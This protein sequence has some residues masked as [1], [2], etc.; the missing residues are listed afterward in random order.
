LIAR[1]RWSERD[2][3][4]TLAVRIAGTLKRAAEVELRL[5]GIANRPAALIA[6]KLDECFRLIAS[7]LIGHLART[8]GSTAASWCDSRIDDIP[9]EGGNR[10]GRRKAHAEK[11]KTGRGIGD[12][13]RLRVPAPALGGAAPLRLVLKS[14]PPHILEATL[15]VMSIMC[16]LWRLYDVAIPTIGLQ[17]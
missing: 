13:L 7:A 6:F 10:R 11:K 12:V 8:H 17:Y 15:N 2:P 3:A 14:H 1:L 4:M 16:A 9:A 5:L